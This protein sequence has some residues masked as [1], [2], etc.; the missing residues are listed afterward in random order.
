MDI[1]QSKTWKLS[2]KLW[3]SE[4]FC[5]A[6]KNKALKNWCEGS[7]HIYDLCQEISL[8]KLQSEILC[9]MCVVSSRRY[10]E[11]WRRK[12]RFSTGW[13]L[14]LL[15]FGLNGQRGTQWTSRGLC[16]TLSLSY[17]HVSKWVHF[18]FKIL[19][20]TK[21]SVITFIWMANSR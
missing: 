21:K 3:I 15:R 4:N 17:W 13:V 9:T 18:C 8:K 19:D 2:L 1:D 11:A 12:G 7:Y 16:K 14:D 10:H 6:L 20:D 5:S